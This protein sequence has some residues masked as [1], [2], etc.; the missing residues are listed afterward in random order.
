MPKQPL[1]EIFSQGLVTS[2]PSHMLSSGEV[3]R[4][5]H[6]V[7]RENNV[8]L[9]RAPDHGLYSPDN[10]STYFDSSTVT[11]LFPAN[12]EGE[13]YPEQLI[14]RVGDDLLSSNIAGPSNNT[15]QPVTSPGRAI[16][17][18]D[19]APTANGTTSINFKTISPGSV[20]A[21]NNY[22]FVG[23]AISSRLAFPP[24]QTTIITS[25]TRNGNG[26]ITS[27]TVSAP[28]QATGTEV[29]SF[30]P[31]CTLIGKFLYAESV[32]FAVRT[33][34][35]GTSGS[36]KSSGVIENCRNSATDSAGYEL[37]PPSG[38][39]N[40]FNL[41]AA[42]G[43]L[44][45]VK[46]GTT[47]IIASGAADS[48]TITKVEATDGIVTKI[49]VDK[50][51]NNAA[52]ATDIK[53]EFL[54]DPRGLFIT[55]VGDAINSE[56]AVLT[57]SACYL[58]YF[59]NGGD[60]EF[61]FM[62]GLGRELRK[63]S[64]ENI[65]GISWDGT[66]FLWDGANPIQRLE[67][68]SRVSFDASTQKEK[69]IV[70]RPVGLL[71]VIETPLFERKDDGSATAGAWNPVLG[72]GIFWFL[73]TEAYIPLRNQSAAAYNPL[74][75]SDMIESAYLASNDITG[76]G[77]G[78]GILS[79]GTIDI[80]RT[81]VDAQTTRRAGRPVPI[82]IADKDKDYVKI[83][84]PKPQ[85]DGTNGYFA[86]HW[87]VYIG[88]KT[89]NFST[90]PPLSSFTRTHVTPITQ[91]TAGQVIVLKDKQTSQTISFS[92]SKT[93][94]AVP[95]RNN[96][97]KGTRTAIDPKTGVPYVDPRTGD[98]YNYLKEGVEIGYV[99]TASAGAFNSS[100]ADFYAAG[101]W[102]I[103]GVATGTYAGYVPSGIEVTVR[104][105]SGGNHWWTC[106]VVTLTSSNALTHAT[107]FDS[108][109]LGPTYKKIGGP[110]DMW[111]LDA[112]TA[113]WSSLRIRLTKCTSAGPTTIYHENPTAVIYYT[114]VSINFNGAPYRCVTYDS[115]IDGPS[116]SDPAN[117]PPPVASLGEVFHGAL[118]LNDTGAPSFIRYS[119]PDRPENFP[120]PYRMKLG[121]KRKGKI[122]AL[123]SFNGMLIVGMERSIKKLASLPMETDTD[124]TQASGLIH[125][126][127]SNTHG[128]V[129]P[130][131]VADFD[132]PGM[133][134]MI[135]YVSTIGLRM[136]DGNLTRALNTDVILKDLV[137]HNYWSKCLL[138]AFPN[139]KW[140]VLYYVPKGSLHGVRSKCLVYSYSEDHIKGGASI[141]LSGNPALTGPLPVTGPCDC[142]VVDA[143]HIVINSSPEVVTTDGEY[144]FVE[145]STEEPMIVRTVT[146]LSDDT[147]VD[148]V[149]APHIK[150]RSIFPAGFTQDANIGSIYLMHETKGSQNVITSTTSYVGDVKLYLSSGWGAHTPVVGERVIHGGW[151]SYPSILEV[152]ENDLTLSAP[153]VRAFTGSATLDS[154]VIIVKVNAGQFSEDEVPIINEY[155]STSV[156]VG[157]AILTDATANRFSM[158]IIKTENPNTGDKNDLGEDM[159]I[160]GIVYHAA[161]TGETNLHTN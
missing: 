58:N 95:G 41:Y 102:T 21:F 10:L 89:E 141:V 84:L 86:T 139:Q 127:I 69:A 90:P 68:R 37:R 138:R 54:Y 117:L 112:T 5:D 35:A 143:S 108:N 62:G 97:Q 135:A 59:P 50:T 123:K 20:G 85:N 92:P 45:T 144:I 114:T 56:D 64:D 47:S 49:W 79:T 44:I 33:V 100:R 153:A 28:A 32:G 81:P 17:Y 12:F 65:D 9:Q 115:Q 125:T 15:F 16:G 106:D 71:P 160:I 1:Q 130:D 157:Q 74:L 76:E 46:H 151:D 137:D 23:R 150:T 70:S 103:P 132:M 24:S 142:Y 105:F 128:I 121:T 145:D 101:D 80:N 110:T 161:S 66:C 29:I 61:V 107:K 72:T 27:I 104:K 109:G 25:V 91:Y 122:T 82:R 136:T 152:G 38:N 39:A 55:A 30:A 159:S 67:Y 154:G 40:A 53:V 19:E 42:V 13:E 134:P 87:C 63:V 149:N 22:A 124:F 11:G 93:P 34:D 3:T 78:G 118:V 77:T 116:F 131:A 73:V 2:R 75:A 43:R 96:W 126:D 4:A 99:W 52:G 94:T 36:I 119:L 51:L 111:G 60:Q 7:Y 98:P 155:R 88:P 148:R 26:D 158:E 31:K 83:T 146:S 57:Y 140:L 113:D 48:C 120:L 14:V 156:G 147:K 8:A 6:C 18:F 133:G 129:G